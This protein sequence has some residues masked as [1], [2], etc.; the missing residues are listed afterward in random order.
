MRASAFGVGFTMRPGK[1]PCIILLYVYGVV[2]TSLVTQ[3]APVI[4]DVSGRF[5]LSHTV[6]GWVISIP[7]LVTA[8]AAVFG[9]WIIDRVGDKQVIVG[10]SAFAMA[11]NVV[12]V[13]AQNTA[14]LFAGRLVEGV[15]Y[16]TLTVGAVTMI[17]RTT[18]GARRAVALGV[19]A[20][21]TAVGISLTLSLIA[22]LAGHGERWRWAFG[23]HAILLAVLAATAFLLPARD[24][25]A[26][27]RQLSEIWTVLRRLPPYRVALA[28]GA[29]AFI[30]TGIMNALTAYLTGRFSVST[31]E[32]AGAGTIAEGFVIV[33]SLSV[34][35]LLKAGQSARRLALIGGAVTLVGGIVLY[36]PP[37]QYFGACASVCAFSLGIGLVNGLIWTCVPGVAPSPE[38]MGATSGLVSQVTYL[39]VLLGPPAIFSTLHD[40]GWTTR[41]GLVVVMVVLQVAPLPIGLAVSRAR[42]GRK[43]PGGPAAE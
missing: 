41:V 38:T 12:V 34:G 42:A 27:V 10:G 21:H 18:T 43:V 17:M 22:P 35:H 8:V 16:L 23:G 31:S 20:S 36:L 11:G 40:G 9:G 29:S 26:P 15:G 28:S 33:G 2:A 1:W 13:L 7:S 6:S 37:T 14:T 3:S 39:G 24:A 5:H 32:A 19:W 25:G 4:G 30:Q